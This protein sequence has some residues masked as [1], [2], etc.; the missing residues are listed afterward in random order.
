MVLKYLDVPQIKD[1]TDYLA[2]VNKYGDTT[3]R[4]PHISALK[5]L[6]VSARF[7]QTLDA[8]DVKDEIS[9]GLPVVAG[10][11]HHGTAAKPSGGGHFI[12]ITGYSD[13][14]WLVQ[15]PYGELDLVNGGWA[16]TS[17]NA[18]RNQRYSFKNI[19]PRFFVEGKANGWGWYKFKYPA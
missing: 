8:Q 14:H 12:V 3:S 4:T 7:K 16:S 13:T 17:R 6:K 15:D 18:G 2:Y 11:L 9:L 10:I 19:D 1:D 5:D